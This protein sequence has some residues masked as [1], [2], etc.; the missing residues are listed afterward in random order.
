MA[1]RP[2]VPRAWDQALRVGIK[3]QRLEIKSQSLGIKSLV[4]PVPVPDPVLGP[5]EE[6]LA[7]AGGLVVE[8]EVEVSFVKLKRGC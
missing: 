3:S 7:T 1:L 6:M 8:L 4:V 2:G 5:T